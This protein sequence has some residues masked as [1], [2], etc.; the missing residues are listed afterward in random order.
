[1]Q[2]HSLLVTVIC[3]R[4]TGQYSYPLF[5]WLSRNLADLSNT[6]HFGTGFSIRFLHHHWNIGPFK[7]RTQIIW[8]QEYSGIQMVTVQLW[9]I[10]WTFQSSSQNQNFLVRFLDLPN[11]KAGKEASRVLSLT[12]SFFRMFRHSKARLKMECYAI[13]F[14]LWGSVR[15]CR[16]L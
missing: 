4:D 13:H 8:I 16:N 2:C 3:Y 1:M 11:E 12:E 14:W 5:I 15:N 6:G 9:S 7:Y 10:L